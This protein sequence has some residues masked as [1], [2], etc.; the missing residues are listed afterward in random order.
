MTIKK[1]KVEIKDWPKT[2]INKIRDHWIHLVSVSFNFVDQTKRIK[3]RHIKHIIDHI[4]D[5]P[6]KLHYF[7]NKSH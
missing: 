7:K 5:K 2:N 3:T 6:V 4:S 1:H